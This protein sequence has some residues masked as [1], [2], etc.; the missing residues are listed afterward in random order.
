MVYSHFRFT[1]CC[2]CQERETVQVTTNIYTRN[3][4]L[5]MFIYLDALAFGQFQIQVFQTQTLHHRATAHTHQQLFSGYTTRSFCIFVGYGYSFFILG[6]TDY[7][8]AQQELDAFL[9]IFGTKHSRK[10]LIHATQNLVHHFDNGYLYTQR[11][12]ERSEFH[13]DDTATYNGQRSRYF[14]VIKRVTV[15]PI[16]HTF[17]TRNRW[18]ESIATGTKQQI[19][20]FVSFFTTLHGVL[21]DNACFTRYN[22]HPM[23]SELGLDAQYQFADHLLLA[24]YNLSQIERSFRNG[25]RILAGML[26][27][28]IYLGRI[29][30]SLGWDATFVQAYATQTLLFEQNHTQTCFSSSF[31]SCISCRTATY[32]CQLISHSIKFCLQDSK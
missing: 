20:A 26:R 10:F 28:I 17:H 11:T 21:V 22:V 27:I 16:I 24:G 7:L 1:D 30:Q 8:G 15:C 31:G 25:Y 2:M 29:K 3:R 18:N 13:T 19:I 6:Q 32:N 23:S 12:K 4:R 5:E 14:L 9:G